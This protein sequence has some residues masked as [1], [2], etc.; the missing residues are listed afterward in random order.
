MAR[1]IHALMKFINIIFCF[2]L[3]LFMMYYL[4]QSETYYGNVRGIYDPSL[5][6]I[7][8]IIA[9]L[10]IMTLLPITAATFYKLKHNQLGFVGVTII[11]LFLLFAIYYMLY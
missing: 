7:Y 5:Q 4:N 10:F 3:L 9:A 8:E 11:N 6:R 1:E 2:T